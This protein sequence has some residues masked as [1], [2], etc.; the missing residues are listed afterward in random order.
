MNIPST[1]NQSCCPVSIPTLCNPIVLLDGWFK[2]EAAAWAMYHRH[3]AALRYCW[4]NQEMLRLS[5]LSRVG[6][7]QECCDVLIQ[8][9]NPLHAKFCRG[10]INI[11]LHFVSFLHIDMKKVVEILPQIRQEPTYSTYHGWWCP[12]EARSQGISSHD[13]DLVKPR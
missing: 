9:L 8:V 10:N 12:G 4:T 6:S 1:I 11:Y 2:K 3:N 13:I 5:A 7:N